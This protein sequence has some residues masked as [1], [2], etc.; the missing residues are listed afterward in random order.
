MV[1]ETSPIEPLS[2]PHAPWGVCAPQSDILLLIS[3]LS[4][5]FITARTSVLD[6]GTG[7]GALAI[8]AV[9]MGARVTGELPRIS[10]SPRSCH[11]AVYGAPSTPL[12]STG[13]LLPRL[14][15]I[16]S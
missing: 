1:A 3:A 7:S 2:V 5:E 4:R 10:W 11:Q 8:A 16:T 15:L 14:Q 12:S 9:C 13:G 6:L